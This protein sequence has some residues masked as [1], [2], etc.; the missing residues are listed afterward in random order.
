LT[1]RQTDTGENMITF[2]ARF[3]VVE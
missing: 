1:D 3:C 2:V